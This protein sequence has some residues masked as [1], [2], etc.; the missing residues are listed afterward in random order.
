MRP[1]LRFGSV[2]VSVCVALSAWPASLSAQP[3][4]QARDSDRVY[5]FQLRR[6]G[7]TVYV[8]QLRATRR[9]LRERLDSIQHE[10]EGLRLDAPDRSDLVRELRALISSL[11]D[12]GQLE[13]HAQL[14][15]ADRSADAARETGRAARAFAQVQR[16][17][18]GRI[19]VPSQSLQPGWI[20]ISAEAPHQR[21]V[22]SDSAYIRY[23]SY[24]EVISVEPNSPA[25]R[26][27]IARG[28]R[29][30]A[31]DGADLR[32]REINLTR[33]LQPSRHVT[34]TVRRD[35]E[36]REFMVVVAKAP[37]QI[38]V[39]QQLSLRDLF[40]D[41]DSIP[42]RV[43]TPRAPMIAPPAPVMVLG[44]MEPGYVPVLGA[45]LVAISD[46]A[47]GHIFGVSSGV[48]VTQV[49]GDPAESSGL[50]GGD[51][52]RRAEGRE[53]TEVGQLRRIV[54][55]HDSDRAVDLEIVRQK[56]TRT[57][58]LRW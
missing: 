58:T 56:R 25:E 11:G 1:R 32:D 24:P 43:R 3:P 29:L 37:P 4:V 19:R 17:L 38:G 16:S 22:R 55:A 30:L 40:S 9:Q 39:R 13:Q 48:L 44:G 46:E 52:I 57:I 20:G 14:G 8:D 7:D 28:D 54:A 53:V 51:V 21:V 2:G 47:F 45:T 27:G 34:I 50:K 41:S 15:F 35:G 5:R 33:L 31:Y 6:S 10:F 49:F 23:F 42:V 26:V 12:L 18:Q 36:E